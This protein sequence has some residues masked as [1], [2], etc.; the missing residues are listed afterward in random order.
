M[1]VQ[2]ILSTT[3]ELI[4]DFIFLWN[5]VQFGQI[6]LDNNFYSCNFVH[7]GIMMLK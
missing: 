6:C 2:T 4:V 1:L 7:E 3:I 5:I